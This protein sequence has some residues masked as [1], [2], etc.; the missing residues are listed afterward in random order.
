MGK[1]REQVLE[2]LLSISRNENDRLQEERIVLRSQIQRAMDTL[3]YVSE[4]YKSPLVREVIKE[5]E[6]V[7]AEKVKI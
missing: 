3:R 2:E 5:I 7:G 6:S 1:T 4:V